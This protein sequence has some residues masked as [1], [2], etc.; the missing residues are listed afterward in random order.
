MPRPRLDNLVEA[1]LLKKEPPLPV[2]IETLITGAERRLADADASA[3]SREGRFD[4]LYNAAHAL[5][6]AALRRRGYR[7]R[8]HRYIVFQALAD[9]LNLP[10]EKWRVLDQAHTARNQFEYRGE[11]PP[12]DEVLASIRRIALEMLAALRDEA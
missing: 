6:L 12:S 3:L 11:E 5:S 1:G 2:E 9:T 4:L 8:Q 10:P 7:P